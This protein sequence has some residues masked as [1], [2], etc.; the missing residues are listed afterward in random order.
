MNEYKDKNLQMNS[1]SK[2]NAF[3]LAFISIP[4]LLQSLQL[5]AQ[6]Y[7]D[8]LNV[9]NRL[10][11]LSDQSIG[12]GDNFQEVSLLLPLEQKN[13]NYILV[14]GDYSNSEFINSSENAPDYSLRSGALYLGYEQKLKDTSWS[15]LILFIP[16]MNSDNKGSSGS[17]QAGGVLMYKLKKSNNL[18]YHFGLY[19]NSEFFGAYFIP[20]V[21]IDWKINSRFNLFGDLPSNLS[22]EMKA[23]KRF[24]LGA[25]FTSN[26]A[27]Y[28][29]HGQND[30][31]Y[32]REGDK[33]WGHDEAHLYV[34]WYF[35]NHSV[36]FVQAGQSIF[37]QY[38]PYN[39]KDELL[40]NSP[41]QKV[42]RDGLFFDIGFA[43][44]FDSN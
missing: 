22:L 28:R 2:K 9:K 15:R 44:R 6:P 1:L 8:L 21:G 14:G 42:K 7:I 10:L 32:I 31:S 39:S 40:T 19:Y 3:L 17:F 43:F 25:S 24:R 13:K 11:P 18:K 16:K 5:S 23:T 33:T 34:N 36:L 35:M 20:L 29:I 12:S 26:I 4:F 30:V 37:R 38:N 27:T 41:I